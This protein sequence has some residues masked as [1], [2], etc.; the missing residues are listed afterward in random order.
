MI[1]VKSIFVLTAKA[2]PVVLVSIGN[3]LL[4]INQPRGPHDHANDIT[5]V[6]TRSTTIIA[7]VLSNV[8]ISDKLVTKIAPIAN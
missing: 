5:Y 8:P 7:S 1:E 3:V 4:G 2:K 6:H